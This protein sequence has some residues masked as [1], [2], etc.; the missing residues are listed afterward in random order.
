[1][2]RIEFESGRS[3]YSHSDG[4][5]CHLFC[6]Y[7]D[8]VKEANNYYD[9]YLYIA[10]VTAF[11]KNDN[12]NLSG[13]LTCKVGVTSSTIRQIYPPLAPNPRETDSDLEK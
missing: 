5:E 3:R 4:T 1:M 10:K 2:C 12:Q 9:C 6:Y 7:T 8:V 13:R 11:E